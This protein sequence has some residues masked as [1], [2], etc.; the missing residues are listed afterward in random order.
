MKKALI[1]GVTGQLGGFLAE[2]LLSKGYHVTGMVRHTSQAML[3]NVEHI[4]D[5]LSLIPGDITDMHSL[6]RVIYSVE[7][8]V[9]FNLAAQSYVAVSWHEPIL[10]TQVTGLGV[11]NLLEAVRLVNK[12][13]RIV[14]ASS[15]EQFG[16]SPAPQSETT[17][18]HPR[19]PSACAKTLAYNYVVN[20]RESYGLFASNAICFNFE[21][22]KR[23]LQFVTRKITMALAKIY[24]GLQDELALGN[25][26][27]KRD[28]NY[29]GD[30][31]L[32]MYL[33]AKHNE[34]DDFVVASGETHSVQEFLEKSFSYVGLNWENYVKIDQSLIRPA[35][36]DVLCGDS[37]K[38]RSSLG[39]KPAVGFEELVHLMVDA[40]MKLVRSS[41][42]REAA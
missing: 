15:S 16:A 6:A 32:A 7:P 10:T 20:M 1:T 2:L 3:S 11:V 29:A 19:S 23:G 42:V 37:N 28:W 4:L 36:V 12:D 38:L 34:P 17:P 33:I 5:N 40:D 41:M 35:E 30:T 27:P 13:I 9:I 31:A 8:D 24:Y 14:Q 22:P 18:F 26:A 25:I 21:S 39:W